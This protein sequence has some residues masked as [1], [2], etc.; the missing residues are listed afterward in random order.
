MDMKMYRSVLLRGLATAAQF[1]PYTAER[2][3]PKL[4]AT[5]RAAAASC[6]GGEGGRR[7]GFA[8]TAANFDDQPSA[9]AQMNAL[10]ALTSIMAPAA[11]VDLT[12]RPNPDDA[13]DKPEKNAGA[14]MASRA[15]AAV[16]G[17]LVLAAWTLL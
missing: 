14:A 9:A 8:W 10:S 5:A 11:P 2:I 6:S 4:L 16:L 1:A 13:D 12:A 17:G 15:P 7:C 3:N